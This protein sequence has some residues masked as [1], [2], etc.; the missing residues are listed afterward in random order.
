MKL[1]SWV[2][3]RRNQ[4]EEAQSTVPA[5]LEPY[6]ESPR[7]QLVRRIVIIVLAVLLLAAIAWA[8]AAVQRDVT[9]NGNDKNSQTQT[10]NK[11]KNQ[12]KQAANNNAGQNPQ[13]TPNQPA[14]GQNNSQNRTGT[15]NIP[16]TGPE[17]VVPIVIAVSIVAGIAHYLW[18]YRRVQG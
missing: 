15:T 14:G 6:Y 2:P 7:R 12:K 9:D 16:N 18:T 8:I 11:D 13:P 3:F 10:Q 5:E 1:P 4:T 17:E